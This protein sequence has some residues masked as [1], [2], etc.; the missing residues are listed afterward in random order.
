MNDCEDL[1]T[2]ISVQLI[3]FT[4]LMLNEVQVFVC[5]WARVHVHIQCRRLDFCVYKVLSSAA[6]N[7]EILDSKA[8]QRSNLN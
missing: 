7:M 8:L 3:N 1:C 5:V 4:T 2:G 6:H